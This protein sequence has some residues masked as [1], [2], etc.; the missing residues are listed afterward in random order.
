MQASSADIESRETE[1]RGLRTNR[2][3]GPKR[4]VH[5]LAVLSSRF[6][7]FRGASVED[8]DSMP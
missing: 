4:C 2:S 5:R 3:C 8:R 6:Q 7:Q 1:S